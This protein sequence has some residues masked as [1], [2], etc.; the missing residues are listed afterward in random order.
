MNGKPIVLIGAGGHASVIADACTIAT[1]PVAGYLS[2]VASS[3]ASFA[4]LQHLGDDRRFIEAGFVLAHQFI[5]GFG[6]VA[7]RKSIALQLQT[8]QADMATIVHPSAIIGTRVRIG[9][10]SFIAAGAIVNPGAFIGRHAIVNTGAILEHDVWLEDHVLIGPGVVLAGAVRCGE[11]AI[12]GAG[13]VVRPGI[14]VGN[15]AQVGAGAAVVRDVSAGDLVVGV[16]AKPVK[17]P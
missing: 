5:I 7:R 14:K 15:G 8:L 16:P 13:A 17:C 11:G 1:L 4:T 6:E 12:I 2:P 9:D 3:R 10:G